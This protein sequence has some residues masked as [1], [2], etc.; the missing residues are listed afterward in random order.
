MLGAVGN[1]TYVSARSRRGKGISIAL[2]VHSFDS[3]LRKMTVLELIR[4]GYVFRKDFGKTASGG[5]LIGCRINVAYTE[6]PPRAIRGVDLR[7]VQ[8]PIVEHH[9][10][11]HLHLKIK[12]FL[13]GRVYGSLLRRQQVAFLGDHALVRA[14]N[15]LETAV[16]DARGIQRGPDCH[17]GRDAQLPAARAVL[18]P[19]DGNPL[20]RGL[21]EEHRPKGGDLVADYLACDVPKQRVLYVGKKQRVLFKVL[22][23]TVFERGTFEHL[24]LRRQFGFAGRRAQLHEHVVVADLTQHDVV[25]AP[26]E[27]MN[28]VVRSD[29]AQAY[30][31]VFVV[32]RE[33]VVGQDW[34]VGSSWG[35][36]KSVGAMSRCIY[37]Y[38]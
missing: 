4:D 16:G 2:A 26:A 6:R 12:P 17:L 3:R 14:R 33:F 21:V 23:F 24:R 10:L 28:L 35:L 37:G 8:R 9:H 20:S 30:V 34:W 19:I 7:A 25:D 18:M 22:H 29:F 36:L 13:V 1:R 27:R 15:N 31:A 11:S 5:D 38:E 32:C